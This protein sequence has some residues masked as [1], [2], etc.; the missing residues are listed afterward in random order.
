MQKRKFRLNILDVAI[1]VAILCSVAVLVFR[2]TINEVFSDPEIVMLEVTFAVDGEEAV[3][4][5]RKAKSTTV[6]FELLS[7][8]EMELDVEIVKVEAELGSLTVPK[9][10]KV[11]VMFTGYG[12]LGRYYTENGERIYIGEKCAVT[13]G[14]A[15]VE[16]VLVSA[17][18][19]GG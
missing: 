6:P 15:H 10:A 14:D 2:D 16:G 8:S 5:V 19:I 17:R 13:V 4:V 9:K 3:S 7:E 11:T 12:K 18:K 1:F